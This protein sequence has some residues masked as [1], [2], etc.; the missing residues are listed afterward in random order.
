MGLW[1]GANWTYV[2]WG[3]YHACMIFIERL[4]KKLSFNKLQN[5][6][7]GWMVVTP[8]AMLGWI[9]FRAQSTNDVWIMF[10]KI[11]MPTKYLFFTMREN[12]YLITALLFVFATAAFILDK[13]SDK[14]KSKI[15]VPLF[16]F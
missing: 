3:L 10:S 2:I 16:H 8:I 9:P 13:Y 12:T 6:I 7:I 4:V 5:P 14:L 15:A 1:H 11:V